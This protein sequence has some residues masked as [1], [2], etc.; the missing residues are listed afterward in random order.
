[1]AFFASR[2]EW[3]SLVL[4]LK[5]AEIQLI[6][7]KTGEKPILLLDDV[8]SEL[9]ETRQ[10]F[11]IEAIQGTQTFITTTHSSFIDELPANVVRHRVVDGIVE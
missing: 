10:K 4:A 2:V 7:E 8:F 1:M 6:E 11:L 3:R 5:F 9:D